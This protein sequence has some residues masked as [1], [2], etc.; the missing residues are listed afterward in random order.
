MGAPKPT[1]ET[2]LSEL[3]VVIPASAN[4]GSRQDVEQAASGLDAVYGQED[5]LTPH[6]EQDKPQ[7]ADR[8]PLSDSNGRA[9][10]KRLAQ[11]LHDFAK[12][13]SWRRWWIRRAP[14]VIATGLLASA[15]AAVY[16]A[17]QAIHS[18]Q[19]ADAQRRRAEQALATAIEN[20]SRIVLD[21]SRRLRAFA[22][23]PPALSREIL[24]R[25]RALQESFIAPGTAGPEASSGAVAALSEIAVTLE[26]VGDVAGAY[27][28]NDHVRQIAERQ[29]S[30]NPGDT[31]WQHELSISYEKLGRL[32]FAQSNFQEALKL[33]Q[34]SL[35]IRDRLVRADSS[36]TSRQRDL[37]VA[38]EKVGDVHLA[39]GNFAEA[40]NAYQA[41]LAIRDRLI[42]A[43]PGDA[44][45]A[46]DFAVSQ[47]K[48]G[49]LRM[50]QKNWPG[51]LKSYQAGL[52]VS[53]R[54][55]KAYPD[56]EPLQ[57]DLAALNDRIGDAETAQGNL[58]EG[59]KSFQ[60]GFVIRD[61]IVK[62]EPGNISWQRDL[63][64][65]Y[66]KIAKIYRET[67]RISEAIDALRQGRE[68]LARLNRLSPGNAAL[69]NYLARFDGQISELTDGAAAVQK[70]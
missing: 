5:G 31:N 55:A 65:S 6:I 14:A 61:R 25:M 58:A 20:S 44:R 17:L 16:V 11:S 8:I 32:R 42:K 43:E 12:A 45:L 48:L 37:G 2:K 36:N 34:A 21:L 38:Y 68:I 53:E 70:R 60:A 24:D 27:D 10:T 54:L 9:I 7:E 46:R 41:N 30:T 33:Y 19:E 67:D 52:P 40:D 29:L 56:N 57:R 18:Q 64:V 1:D 39:L 66:G 63:V 50:A 26:L 4:A 28:T 35:A 13:S 47:Y 59:L 49:D 69:G 51:A 23:L 3:E 15:A 22:D 62:F